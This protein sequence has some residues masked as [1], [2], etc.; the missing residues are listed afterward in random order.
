MAEAATPRESEPEMISRVVVE[1]VVKAAT[2]LLPP[3]S[4]YTVPEPVR[5]AISAVSPA[6]GTTPPTQFAATFQSPPVGAARSTPGDRRQH[7]AQLERLDE[8]PVRRRYRARTLPLP[9]VE[10]ADIFFQGAT[11]PAMLSIIVVPPR[12]A[13]ACA[14]HVTQAIRCHASEH[15]MQV[16]DSLSC[17]LKNSLTW[18]VHESTT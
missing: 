1:S 3:E 15:R 11:S 10:R 5:P 4:R 14:N 12:M 6:P 16:E 17:E 2:E 13:Q 9:I 7:A 8:R 18:N